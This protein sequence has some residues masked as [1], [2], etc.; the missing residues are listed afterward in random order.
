MEKE[1]KNNVICLFDMDGTL[2]RPRNRI[3]EDMEKFMNTLKGKAAIGIISGSDYDK[4]E[5]QMFPKKNFGVKLYEKYDYI[6]AENGLMSF[7]NGELQPSESITSYLGDE[8]LQTFINFC[9]SYMSNLVL[10][11]KRGNFIELRSGMINICP[12]GRTCT[13]AERDE[14]AAFDAI[15][16]VRKKF[17]EALNEKFGSDDY[18]LSIAIG[19]QISIDIFPRNWDKSYC[20]KFLKGFDKI[21]FFGDKTFPGGNDYELYSHPSTIGYRVDN[22]EH[23]MKLVSQLFGMNN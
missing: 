23:T 20:L 19:G 16:D 2:T 14:F 3:T 5:E 17:V 6:F 22:P 9:F 4:L 15:H 8:K 18:G 11:C 10:P 13:Q 1:Q 7:I 21:Y 12:V